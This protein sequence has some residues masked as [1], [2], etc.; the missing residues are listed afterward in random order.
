MLKTRRVLAEEFFAKTL[1]STLWTGKFWTT[2]NIQVEKK[3]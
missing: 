1:V 3:K 2:S